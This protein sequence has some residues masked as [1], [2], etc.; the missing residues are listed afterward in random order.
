MIGGEGWIP[1]GYVSAGSGRDFGSAREHRLSGQIVGR[2]ERRLG[3]SLT[4]AA[5]Q[6]RARTMS[7]WREGL[8][9]D[10]RSAAWWVWRERSI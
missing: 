5:A 4:R 7:W 1:H 3:K 8:V 9:L 2:L 10:T 6:K